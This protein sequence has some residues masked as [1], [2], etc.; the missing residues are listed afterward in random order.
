MARRREQA[1][2]RAK[3]PAYGRWATAASL[4]MSPRIASIAALLDRANVPHTGWRGVDGSVR[5]RLAW[6]CSD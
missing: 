4:P 6:S 5:R 2:S 3:A 1:S